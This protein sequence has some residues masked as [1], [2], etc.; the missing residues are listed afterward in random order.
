M[1][2]FFLD[3]NPKIAARYHV[4]KHV[5]KMPLET[6][7]LLCGVHHIVGGL[8]PIQIPYKLTHKN[9]PSAIWARESLSNYLWL[10]ELG[11]A[12]CM[13]YTHRYG[14]IHKCED[15]I[16][17]CK[18]HLPNIPDKGLTKVAQAMPN[19]YRDVDPVK[20]YRTYYLKA[21]AHLFTWKRRETPDWI[22]KDIIN[23]RENSGSI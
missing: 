11:F 21:K 20:A 17:W 9:H 23:E 3:E 7:Q 15:V 13:E 18:K 12:I 10:V 14:K 16:Q 6:A 19:E 5:V 8:M 2:I 4:D 22:I 1:N